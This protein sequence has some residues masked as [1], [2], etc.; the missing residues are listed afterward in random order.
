V[1]KEMMYSDATEWQVTRA[2]LSNSMA[3]STPDGMRKHNQWVDALMQKRGLVHIG[4][5]RVGSGPEC[6]LSPRDITTQQAW[7]CPTETSPQTNSA[8]EQHTID[9]HQF[10]IDI[11][12]KCFCAASESPNVMCSQGWQ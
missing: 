7:F 12:S 9:V 11:H 3:V 5:L 10:G 6:P 1:G 2:I 4:W 8:P